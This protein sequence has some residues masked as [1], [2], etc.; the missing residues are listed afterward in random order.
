[1]NR[2]YI[3]FLL[4]FL[5][6]LTVAF[7]GIM[8]W[9]WIQRRG[10]RGDTLIVHSGASI[11]VAGTSKSDKEMGKHMEEIKIEQFTEEI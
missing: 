7:I 3:N 9:R 4:G 6:V 11:T 5:I 2:G 8:V 1:M 10:K